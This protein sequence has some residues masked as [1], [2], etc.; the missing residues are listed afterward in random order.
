MIYLVSHIENDPDNF[1]PILSISKAY[2]LLM[3]P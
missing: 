1:K 3:I 2:A